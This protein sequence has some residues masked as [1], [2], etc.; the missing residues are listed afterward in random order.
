M[1]FVFDFY[2]SKRLFLLCLAAL[3]KKAIMEIPKLKQ[4]GSQGC[5]FANI[6]RGRISWLRS[7]HAVRF[8]GTDVLF[9]ITFLHYFSSLLF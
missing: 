9:C 8:K 5:M 2:F 7:A 1:Q 6:A 3:L 4:A